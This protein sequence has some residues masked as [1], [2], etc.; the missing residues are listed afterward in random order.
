M[1]VIIK[2]NRKDSCWNSRIST[3]SISRFLSQVFMIHTMHFWFESAITDH[4]P[5]IQ[6]MKTKES[7]RY[8]SFIDNKNLRGELNEV[9]WNWISE[10]QNIDNLAKSFNEIII[11]LLN[12]HTHHVNFSAKKF[13]KNS[14]MTKSLL[15]SLFQQYRRGICRM[16]RRRWRIWWR[17]WIY[18]WNFFSFSNNTNG[19][20]I[21]AK[22][23]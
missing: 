15:K 1:S 22:W 13:P 7:T 8:K 6:I 3:S 11:Q 5:D 21:N 14:W 10:T 23:I 17:R 4:C 2:E 20:N 12:K 9:N 19:S 16:Y 18:T